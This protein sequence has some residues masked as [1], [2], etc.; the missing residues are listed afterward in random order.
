[1]SSSPSREHA[2]NSAVADSPTRKP[3]LEQEAASPGPALRRVLAARG[4]G[5]AAP[6]GDTM[7]LQ[8]SLGNRAVSRMLGARSGSAGQLH[9]IASD[10]VQGSP[11]PYPFLDKIQRS[12]GGHDVAHVQAFTGSRATAASRAIGAEAYTRG[13]KVAFGQAPSL[14]T[15]AHEAAHTVQQRAGVR[16]EGG[17]SRIG[18]EHERH[19]DAVAERVVQGQSAETLLSSLARSSTARASS[20]PAVQG[21]WISRRK[22]NSTLHRYWKKTDADTFDLPS[23]WYTRTDASGDWGQHNLV[24]DAPNVV[25]DFPDEA[26]LLPAPV[27]SHTSR[28]NRGNL[29]ADPLS[30]LAQTY[31]RNAA[32]TPSNLPAALEAKVAQH[33]TVLGAPLKVYRWGE[34]QFEKNYVV[35]NGFKLGNVNFGSTQYGPGMYVATTPWGS[36]QYAS[37]KDGTIIEVTIPAGTLCVDSSNRQVFNPSEERALQGNLHHPPFLKLDSISGWATIKDDTLDLQIEFY[38]PNPAELGRIAPHLQRTGE[39]QGYTALQIINRQLG[40]PIPMPAKDQLLAMFINQPEMKRQKLQEYVRSISKFDFVPFMLSK[41]KLD[42]TEA[43]DEFFGSFNAD[44]ARYQR[45]FG[46]LEPTLRVWA[47]EPFVLSNADFDAVVVKPFND[48]VKQYTN[49]RD[50]KK[51]EPWYKGW[52]LKYSSGDKQGKLTQ[53]GKRLDTFKRFLGEVE[54]K[55]SDLDEANRDTHTGVKVG[56]HHGILPRGADKEAR[57]EVIAETML[58]GVPQVAPRKTPKAIVMLGLPG[59]GKSSVIARVAPDLENY[60]V[61]DPDAAK[62]GLPEYQAGRKANNRGIAGKVHEESKEITQ[63]AID[64]AASTRRNLIYDTTG[65]GVDTRM[66]PGL[67][68]AGYEVKVVYVHVPFA[69]AQARVK[70]RAD[71]TGRDVPNEV[72]NTVRQMLGGSL[73]MLARQANTVDIYD[74]SGQQPDLSWTGKG[75]AATVAKLNEELSKLTP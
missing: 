40:G 39:V 29:T 1:M 73:N 10:G 67:R 53:F 19:A 30:N 74:N 52:G 64:Q 41:G 28:Y 3:H 72:L 75:S 35:N 11:S 56:R 65:T 61:A 6:P 34:Y 42:F 54:Q 25:R 36:A 48:S 20:A 47:S 5:K 70:K 37:P 31:I 57:K 26:G 22:E 62:E 23:G 44:T 71:E 17:I 66:I 24:L 38:R 51:A 55:H 58:R 8:C 9:A 13:A 32:A 15:A 21:A 45:H 50:A 33:G 69:T 16:P 14:R 2:L 18:D 7:A 49:E 4:A 59:S 63:H 12:F 27:E 60:V 43:V 68:R 46:Y